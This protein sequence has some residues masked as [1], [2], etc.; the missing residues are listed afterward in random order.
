MPEQEQVHFI[1]SGPNR[2]AYLPPDFP[3]GQPTFDLTRSSGTSS[4]YT[5]P[6]PARSLRVQTVPIA[7]PNGSESAPITVLDPSA[8]ALVI[9][10][11]QNFF[12]S[13]A[14][15]RDAS[16]PGHKAIA[17][18]ERLVP[19]CRDAG[20]GIVWCNWGFSEDDLTTAP[21]AVLKG[22]GALNAFKK[23]APTPPQANIEGERIIDTK[24]A[25]I[26]KG[27]GTPMGNVTL[28]TGEEVDA[29][30]LLMRDQ[31][32]SQLAPPLQKLYEF[33]LADS[34]PERRDTWAHKNRMSGMW[35]TQQP[36]YRHLEE[37]GIRSVI[38]AG[39]NTD[40]CVQGTFVDAYNAGWDCILLRDGCGT[41]TPGGK[42]VT[43]WNAGRS[44]GFMVDSDALLTGIRDATADR[45]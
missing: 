28:E 39:V 7:Q 22:F 42:E 8:T 20:I 30:R 43:E 3:S 17:V 31:W 41:G 2:W 14:L 16:G 26:Y 33:S 25:R 45:P 35:S 21:P 15:G 29:G 23:D 12:L 9:I 32:N 18:L 5:P 6:D 34:R 1:G 10:D 4:T 38:F 37:R 24:P 36:L 44:W 13:P 19:Q 11:M 27:F 40:Q